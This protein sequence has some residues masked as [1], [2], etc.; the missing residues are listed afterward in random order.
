MVEQTDFAEAE[1]HDAVVDK[2]EG[3]DTDRYGEAFDFE[4]PLEYDDLHSRQLG[5]RIYTNTAAYQD[6]PRKDVTGAESS[7]LRLAI[8]RQK[9]RYGL[10]CLDPDDSDKRMPAAFLIFDISFVRG[11]TASSR[12]K[13]AEIELEFEDAATVGSKSYGVQL[14]D[15]HQPSVAHFQPR[16]FQG[17]ITQVVGQTSMSFKL[18]ASDPSGAVGAK[19]GA[20]LVTATIREGS[21]LIHGMATEEPASTVR[22]ILHEDELKKTGLP[23]E[24]SL[25]VIVT[26][27]PGRKFAAYVRA[28]ANVWLGFPKLVAGE[29][30]DPLYF[31]PP[32][33]TPKHDL[34]PDLAKL[35]LLDNLIPKTTMQIV[36][37]AKS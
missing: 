2:A 5:S 3:S 26:C 33:D 35:A 8:R 24:I 37:Q 14:D 22:W 30:D 29:K 13:M 17:P 20:S 23:G 31:S 7:S 12:F 10:T 36:A 28:K 34:D 21:F 4:I 11:L 19:A 25:G 1:P 9:V 32:K 27:T 6:E 18:S 15:K 16:H